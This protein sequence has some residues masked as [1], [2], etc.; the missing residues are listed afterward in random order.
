MAKTARHGP[1]PSVRHHDHPLVTVA[2]T[3]ALDL[4]APDPAVAARQVGAVAALAATE[5]GDPDRAVLV[6]PEVRGAAP[7]RAV[8]APDPA[9]LDPRAV[10]PFRSVGS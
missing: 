5:T 2:A 8:V 10:A 3:G 6:A 1:N 7:G 9:D 4:A